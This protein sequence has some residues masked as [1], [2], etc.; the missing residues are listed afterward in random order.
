[1]GFRVKFFGAVLPDLSW[2]PRHGVSPEQY[3]WY[4]GAA[5]RYSIPLA[6]WGGVKGNQAIN[7]GKVDRGVERKVVSTPSVSVLQRG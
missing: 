3:R 6:F 4:L 1:M 5:S 7:H 2:S